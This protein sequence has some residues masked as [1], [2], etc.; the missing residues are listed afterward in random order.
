MK[1]ASFFLFLL[2]PLFAGNSVFAQESQ[3]PVPTPRAHLKVAG[4]GDMRVTPDQAVV[5]MT[6]KTTDMDFNKAVQKLNE[7]TDRLYKKLLNAGFQREEIKTS[8]LNVQENGQW[9]DG[10]YIDSGYVATQNLELRFKRDHQ[11]MAKLMDAF[12]AEKGAEAL[13]HFGFALSDD[14]RQQAEEEL[15][16]RAIQDARNK[17]AVIA[18]TSG[19]K[20]GQISNIVYG[21]PDMRPVPMY[22]AA[23]MD[24]SMRSA[25]GQEMPNIEVQEI[26]MQDTITIYWNIE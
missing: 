22:E 16:R 21:Q 4:T 10:N 24:M 9:R 19:V 8:Q 26:E 13:F 20:L 14:A 17:A 25:K 6:V 12:S 3:N 11:R 18:K 2:L 15:I 5:S 1:R 7:K 23:M